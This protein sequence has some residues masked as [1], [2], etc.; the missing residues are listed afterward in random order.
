MNDVLGDGLQL[1]AAETAVE[2]HDK[3]VPCVAVRVEA[4]QALAD[5]ADLGGD[6]A[7]KG[8]GGPHRSDSLRVIPGPVVRRQL[9]SGLANRIEDGRR[10]E[11]S[12]RGTKVREPRRHVPR[13]PDVS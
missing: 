13:G 9:L 12:K 2:R 7:R 10:S 3:L 4:Q 11:R 6:L 1:G 5:P 8:H